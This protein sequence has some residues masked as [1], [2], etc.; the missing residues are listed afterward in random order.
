MRSLSPRQP[1][2]DELTPQDT[3]AVC[4][5]TYGKIVITGES[6]LLACRSLR[7]SI[8]C[9]ETPTRRPWSLILVVSLMAGMSI[10]GRSGTAQVGD[11]GFERPD[12][13]LLRSPTMTRA[14]ETPERLWTPHIGSTFY[15]DHG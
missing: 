9:Q 1:S 4:I 12:L 14:L 7:K 6:P 13:E 5:V 8:A 3:R 2:R 15:H 11:N 10:A